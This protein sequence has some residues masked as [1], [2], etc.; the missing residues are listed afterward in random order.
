M[1]SCGR[2]NAL[3]RC[4]Q[5]SGAARRKNGRTTATCTSLTQG[6]GHGASGRLPLRPPHPLGAATRRRTSH[7]SAPSLCSGAPAATLRTSSA[8]ATHGHT[9]SSLSLHPMTLD[10]QR[11]VTANYGRSTHVHVRSWTWLAR[12]QRGAATRR[13]SGTTRSM[14][15][16]V[17]SPGLP[18]STPRCMRWTCGN[19][20]GMRARHTKRVLARDSRSHVLQVAHRADERRRPAG[21]SGGD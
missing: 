14:S 11:A 15:P 21:C 12:Q 4:V 8:C 3:S 20:R 17:M 10:S 7:R 5:A 1:A 18:T 6:R 2:A 13:S 19:L 9:R 16:A